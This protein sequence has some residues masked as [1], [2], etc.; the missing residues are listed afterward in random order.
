MRSKFV[1]QSKRRRNKKKP[2]VTLNSSISCL[3]K[4]DFTLTVHPEL[5]SCLTRSWA[6]TFSCRFLWH[7]V[8]SFCHPF[9]SA[10]SFFPT[11]ALAFCH[12]PCIAAQFELHSLFTYHTLSLWTVER[13]GERTREEKCLACVMVKV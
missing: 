2:P 6:G 7:H 13:D 8:L 10:V 5:C 1:M 11:E 4:G 12:L 9:L 3:A